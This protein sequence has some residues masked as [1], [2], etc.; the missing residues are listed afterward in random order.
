MKRLSVITIVLFF[1]IGLTTAAWAGPGLK[2]IKSTGVLKVGSTVTGVPAT[3]MDPH[4]GKIVGIM[5]DVA[6]QIADSLGVKL[7]VVETPWAALIPSLQT[8]KIDL[9]SA[10]ML[11]T[12]K[13]EKVIDFSVPVYRYCEALIVKATDTKPYK[14]IEE[15]KGL[16]MGGQVGTVYVKGMEERGI[17]DV[18]VYNNI[19]DIMMDITDGRIDGAIVDGPVAKWLV[20]T[21]PQF[22]VRVVKTYVPV[23]CGHIGIGV[24]KQN[25]DLLAAVNKA[26]EKMKKDGRIQQILHKWGQ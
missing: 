25:K 17:K 1:L 16:R 2:R 22:K 24:N 3:F 6:Q 14:S 23:M 4:T 7:K 11:I 9:I 15:L 26:V 18:K 21:K 19:G 10:A 8:Q 5:V 13:R 20:K 12:P